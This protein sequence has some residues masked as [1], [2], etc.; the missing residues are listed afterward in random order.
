MTGSSRVSARHVPVLLH[1][2][3]AALAPKDGETYID[4][5]FGAGG[6]TSAI[7]D[8]ARCA[9]LALDR[10]PNAVNDGRAVETNYAPR[11]K[12]VQARFADLADVA[13]GQGIQAVDGVVLDVGVSSM[14]LDT[15][16]R[17]FS[18]QSDGPLDM[19]M[20]PD[21][22]GPTAAAVVNEWPEGD[23][24]DI[25]YGL[26][27][28]K[29]A[30]RIAR[31]LVAA[32][33][34][35]RL[36]RTSEL[37]SLVAQV[38]G[39]RKDGRHPATQTFQALRIFVNDELGELAAGLTAAERL[40][41]PGGRLVVVTFHS[42]EDRLVK[43]FLTTRAGRQ[44]GTS[45]HSPMIVS[46]RL[47]SFRFVN[48]RRLTSGE[49]EIT[50]NPRARSAGLRSAIRTDADAWPIDPDMVPGPRIGAV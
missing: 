30:R 47:P 31:A 39:R 24:A 1:E 44:T 9:V 7:L 36:T 4:A 16:D 15:A 38:L 11:L 21:G 2:M 48:H 17:G 45:R 35:A 49:S 14:Q 18:F 3:L 27:E 8:A 42:L 13:L 41:K 37:A 22:G 46:T 25:I 50:V 19:R 6:Y 32:R 5:T 28:E 10:D 40:L 23:L 33:E 43:Q 26:G 12:L 34:K 29:G 20:S